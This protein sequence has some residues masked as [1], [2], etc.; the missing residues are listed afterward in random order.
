MGCSGSFARAGRSAVGRGSAATDCG[1]PRPGTMPSKPGSQTLLLSRAARAWRPGASGLV[2]TE[3]PTRP[4]RSARAL[5][6][7]DARSRGRAG[8]PG[9][10]RGRPVPQPRCVRQAVR[11][12]ARG[13]G[14]RP[15]DEA[16]RP[17]RPRRGR[18]EPLDPRR[19]A[20]A[21]PAHRSVRLLDLVAARAGDRRLP[22]PDRGRR[23]VARRLLRPRHGPG[24][25]A[26]GRSRWY[27]PERC[28]VIGEPSCRSASAS[29]CAR[30][31]SGPRSW[32]RSR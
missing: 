25:G 31:T 30:V 29:R 10:A 4:H 7:T 19:G 32:P 20:E 1:S 17:L 9:R 14:A 16:A 21:V 13:H 2:I 3:A 27:A 15:R 11:R 18:A 8:G 24:G 12:G 22:D 26:V 5:V 28:L 23:P 6:P